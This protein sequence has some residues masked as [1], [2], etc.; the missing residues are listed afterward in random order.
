[1]ISW[2]AYQISKYEIRGTYLEICSK[3]VKLFLDQDWNGNH[4]CFGHCETNK[5]LLFQ[6]KYFTG[7]TLSKKS[8]FDLVTDMV[9]SCTD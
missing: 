2:I 1:M 7:L 5:L 6:L 3:S 8:L 4:Y 9:F